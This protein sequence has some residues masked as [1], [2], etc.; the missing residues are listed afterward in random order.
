MRE[1]YLIVDEK[2]K[3]ATPKKWWNGPAP[4]S[5]NI[6]HQPIIESFVDG[7]ISGT[8]SWAIMCPTCF[9]SGYGAGLG[10]GEGRYY[11]KQS[12][13]CFLKVGG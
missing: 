6:C 9:A 12:N 4:E 10:L 11:R 8:G 13:L 2:I 5:C 7:R 3:K 1:H